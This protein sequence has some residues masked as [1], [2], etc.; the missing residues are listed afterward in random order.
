MTKP[1][2]IAKHIDQIKKIFPATRDADPA[3]LSAK[4]R[5]LERQAHRSAERLCD[6]SSYSNERHDR[7]HANVSLELN[8]LLHFREAKISVHVN[9]DARGYALKI[10]DADVRALRDKG[11]DIERDWGGYGILWPDFDDE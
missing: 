7:V 2:R 3:V 10:N 5:M 4:L 6:D 1:E 9:S 8:A 11:L